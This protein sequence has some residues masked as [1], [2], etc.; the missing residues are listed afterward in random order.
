[1]TGGMDMAGLAGTAGLVSFMMGF[2]IKT[3]LPQSIKA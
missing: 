1:M 2:L 3:C